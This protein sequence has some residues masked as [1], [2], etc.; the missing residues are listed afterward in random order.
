LPDTS[1]IPSNQPR[2]AVT[3]SV[4][5]DG[6]KLPDS[7]P[8]LSIVVQKQVNRLPSAT[9]LVQDGDAATG[10]FAHSNSD[11]LVP[12]KSIEIKAGHR[13][14][15][16]TIF[17]GLVIR[18]SA[19]VRSTVSLL[20]I[21]CRHEA[22]KMTAHRKN[23][24][25]ADMNDGDVASQLCSGHG[26][27]LNTSGSTLQH[28]QLVQYNSTDWDFMLCRAEANGAWLVAA[29][30]GLY[31][32]PPNFGQEP[33]LTAQYGATIKD[34]DAEIDSRLQYEGW[35]AIGW[36]PDEQELIDNPE[37][38]EPSMPAAGNLA[39]TDLATAAG[40]QTLELR[41]SSLPETELKKWADAAQQKMRLTKIRGK[42]RIDGSAQPQP[43]KVLEL[44]GAGERFDGRV[45][46]SG[47]RHQIE[48][49]SWE[50]TIQFGET[51]QWHAEVFDVAPLPAGGLVPHIHGLQVG[52]VTSLE[53][54]EGGERVQVRMPMVSGTDDGAWMR[55]G[56]LDAGKDRGFIFRPEIDDEV[57]VGFINDDP[58]YGVV[59]GRL[60]SA[61]NTAPIAASNDNHHKG[62]VSRSDMQMLFDDEKKIMT[63][64]TPGGHKVVLDDDA[65]SITAQDSHGNKLVM[66]KDGI[67]MESIKDVKITAS[68][69]IKAEA[70]A[71][72]IIKA[73][74][75]AKVEGSGTAEISSGGNTTVKGAMVAIN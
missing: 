15:E 1:T 28:K 29:D 45:M 50:T 22:V 61:K 52:V 66:D 19:K 17:K 3:F 51:P 12:G 57:I 71:N 21:E 33:V 69:D 18:H 35:K 63:L 30:D 5:S 8:V 7:I 27:S 14:D 11:L 70:G 42:V 59:L 20:V 74:A 60:H 68:A 65:Q 10:T 48:R 32:Q 44:S 37:G 43:G 54:P 58:R 72:A 31:W 26:L 40:N 39:A 64:S 36:N 49:N 6:Q 56:T 67:T 46:I 47:V 38:A 2:S 9:I 53:D 13:N 4:L 16:E 23:A 62:Y 55:L 25:F 73:G 34:L 75:S 41:H 24:Y